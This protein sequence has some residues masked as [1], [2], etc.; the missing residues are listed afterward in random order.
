MLF[1]I[2]CKCIEQKHKQDL[3]RCVNSIRKFHPQN[4]IVIVDSDSPDKSYMDEIKSTVNNV[5]IE[6][7]SNTGYE[8]GAMWHVYENYPHYETIVFLQDSMEL[9]RSLDEF[10]DSQLKVINLHNNWFGALPQDREFAQKELP[11]TNYQY[12]EDNF[13]MVQFNS[14]IIKR[15]ILDTLKENGLNKVIP[16]NKFGSCAMERIL[17]IVLTDMG[18]TTPDSILPN[19]TIKKIWRSRK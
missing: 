19:G 9:T 4:P 6:D 15:T 18:L 12:R 1:S 7:I 16:T 10:E 5:H 14:M 11:K 17:G 3:I 13:K 8:T 2:V